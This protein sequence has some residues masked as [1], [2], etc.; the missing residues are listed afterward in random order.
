MFIGYLPFR[1][2][3]YIQIIYFLRVAK[4][5]KK[6]NCWR[7]WYVSPCLCRKSSEQVG[8]IHRQIYNTVGSWLRTAW[9]T[10]QQCRQ[11]VSCFQNLN[12]LK[13]K[14]TA[15]FHLYFISED[16]HLYIK[17]NQCCN[18]N[19]TLLYMLFNSLKLY[20]NMYIFFSSN[21]FFLTLL[22]FSPQWSL[23]LCPSWQAWSRVRR[24]RG[25]DRLR[26]RVRNLRVPTVCSLQSS[27]ALPGLCIESCTFKNV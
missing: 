12:Y 17:R 15:F 18:K 13:W 7:K 10:G 24:C 8:F 26:P 20:L 4:H 14:Y 9:L 25:Q 3:L 27:S 16:S 19:G 22:F 6:K 5:L 11:A 21:L 23:L 2:N 1:Y